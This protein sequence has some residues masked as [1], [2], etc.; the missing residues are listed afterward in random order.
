MLQLRITIDSL[1]SYDAVS[2]LTRDKTP[3]T[4]VDITANQSVVILSTSHGLWAQSGTQETQSPEGSAEINISANEIS[5]SSEKSTIIAFSNSIVNLNADRITLSSQNGTAIDVRGN[6]TVNLGNA[7]GTA[8]LTINGD[9][10]FETPNQVPDGDSVNSGDKINAYVSLNLTEGSSWTGRAYQL[11]P[12]KNA[13]GEW[14]KNNTVALEDDRHPNYGFVTGLTVNIDNGGVWNMTG[15]SFVNNAAV[16]DGGVVNV[17][18]DVKTVNA[19]SLD[20]NGGVFNLRGS[21][22]QKV[23]VVSLT[24]TGGTV[25]AATTVGADGT[26]A[27]ASMIVE[28]VATGEDAPVMTVN[29]TGITSDQ[30]TNENVNDLKAVSVA[31]GEG[32]VSTLSTIENVDEGD[33]RG[34][35]TRTTRAADGTP[36]AEFARNTKLEDFSAVNAMTLVQW[37]NEINHL[38]K[39]LGDIRASESA[40]GAWARVYGGTSEWGDNSAVEMDHTTIQVGGDY[41]INPHWIVGGAFSYTDSDADLVNGQAEGE[42]Y[43]LAAYATWMGETGSYLDMI[44]RYGHL[45]NDISAG[46][47]VLDTS[48][49]AFSLS[50]EGGHQFRFMERAYVEPQIEVTYGFISG[51]DATASNGVKVE[52]DDYQNL[53]T[54]VGLR[55]GFDFPEKAGTIYA[56]LSYSYDFLGDADGTATK[57]GLHEDLNEDLGGGWVSYGVGAQFKLGDNAF[58]YGELERTSGGDIDNPYLFNVGMRWNF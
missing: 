36:S 42:S 30:L 25:N 15:D 9:I 8:V 38:T 29:Y 10:V 37:R 53:I 3:G 40:V 45:K 32:E 27:T 7:D 55:T 13:E 12:V 14:V 1:A 58:A 48:S 51:D 28:S 54:R 34:K 11:F 21:S 44:A 2:A 56:M 41:R 18:K 23:N 20:L 6:S 39:R 52:Q 16:N 46:N 49:N 35:W 4:T 33:I 17:T 57:D 26:L 22:E 5:I 50:F 24:G 43:S 31:E 47:M 19:G